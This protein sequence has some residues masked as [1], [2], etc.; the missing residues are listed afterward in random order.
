MKTTTGS[1]LLTL[2][3][4]GLLAASTQAIAVPA[5]LWDQSDFMQSGG[6]TST[7]ILPMG[8]F[9]VG[10]PVQITG[11]TVWMRDTNALLGGDS[12]ANGL[13]STFSGRL[14]WYVWR[15]AA[16]APGVL[17]ASGNTAPLVVDTGVD[18]TPTLN[19]PAEDIFRVSG[20]LAQALELTEAGHYWFGI[21]EGDVGESTDGTYTHWQPAGA[22]QGYGSAY[23]F[24]GGIGL[25]NLFGPHTAER[26]FVL[27]G[28]SQAV[29]EPAPLTLVMAGL[30]AW[31]L[32]RRRAA[33]S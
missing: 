10:Q 15:D 30:S 5:V 25:V 19:T 14:S 26:A 4:S 21:R 2:A 3:V 1:C 33:R 31:A 11:F 27:S 16:E 13:F 7:E 18:S 29:P 8:D 32:Q 22:V 24:G 12:L 28:E 17:L 20:V 23:F 6:V 9:V